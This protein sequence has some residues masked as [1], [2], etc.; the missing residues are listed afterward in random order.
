M[1]VKVSMTNKRKTSNKN[2]KLYILITHTISM[3]LA[4]AKLSGTRQVMFDTGHSYKNVN[5]VSLFAREYSYKNVNT[6]SLFAGE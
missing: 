2:E 1:L 4:T 6:V 5:A 3:P